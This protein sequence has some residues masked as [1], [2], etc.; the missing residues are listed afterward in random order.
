MPEL[1]SIKNEE[2]YQSGEKGNEGKSVVKE[3]E[4]GKKLNVG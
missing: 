1:V 4:K 3:G 2:Q